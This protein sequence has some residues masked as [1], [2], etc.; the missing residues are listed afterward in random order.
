MG[1]K[2]GKLP[3]GVDFDKNLFRLTNKKKID[4]QSPIKITDPK[5]L[6]YIEPEDKFKFSVFQLGLHRFDDKGRGIGT[7]P[8]R[9]V[10]KKLV[11]NAPICREESF[12]INDRTL[13]EYCEDIMTDSEFILTLSVID[14]SKPDDISNCI[15]YIIAAPFKHPNKKDDDA[16]DYELKLICSKKGKIPFGLIMH[17]I[18]VQFLFNNKTDLQVDNIYLH[19]ASSDLIGYYTN[20]GYLIGSKPCYNASDSKSE[21]STDADSDIDN[22]DILTEIHAEVLKRNSPNDTRL[23]YSLF[24]YQKLESF[25]ERPGY[26]KNQFLLDIIKRLEPFTVDGMLCDQDGTLMKLCGFD[27]QKTMKSLSNA[28]IKKLWSIIYSRNIFTKSSRMRRLTS[29]YKSKPPSSETKTNPRTR[30]KT[31]KIGRS[32]SNGSNKSGTLFQLPPRQNS[33][34]SSESFDSDFGIDDS[35]PVTT[36]G[37]MLNPTRFNTRLGSTSAG[38]ATIKKNKKNNKRNKTKININNVK[39]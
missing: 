38:G 32:A 29:T 5:Q 20:L 37:P 3:K 24:D 1:G 6:F 4:E 12:G 28:K 9:E 17:S 31:K 19:S 14:K 26:R 18:M 36:T 8:S 33:N 2:Q 35:S 27:A 25:K 16:F 11:C 23:F 21:S 10:Y 39:N 22:K 34:L 13:T 7:D 30:T 15:S